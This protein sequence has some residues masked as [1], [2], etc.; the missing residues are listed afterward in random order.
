MYKTVFFIYTCV[1]FLPVIPA[2]AQDS[3]KVKG[4]DSTMKLILSKYPKTFMN[5]RVIDP[6]YAFERLNIFKLSGFELQN[7]KKYNKIAHVFLYTSSAT[8]LTGISFFRSNTK[9]NYTISKTISEI[10]L[11]EFIAALFFTIRSNNHLKNAFHL[12]NKE[13]CRQKNLLQ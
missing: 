10:F 2:H 4:C 13:I 3:S 6:H 5:G 7:Y 9:Q 12:Y 11:A 1:F 8:I